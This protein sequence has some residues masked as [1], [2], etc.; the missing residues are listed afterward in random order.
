MQRVNVAE[1]KARLSGL[2]EDALRGEDVVIARRN[3][4]LVRLI[5][6]EEARRRP[7][8]GKLRGQVR[9]APDFD[10]PLAD[11]ADYRP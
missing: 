8:F 2:I 3:V 7:R 10:A 9:T 11:F 5:A 6:V 1:A 4:P